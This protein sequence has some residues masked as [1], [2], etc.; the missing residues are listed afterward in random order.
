MGMGG[1]IALLVMVGL[2]V[3]I[4][5][6]L[7]TDATVKVNELPDAT[8]NGDLQDA[9]RLLTWTTVACWVSLVMI[10]IG[11]GIV[12]YNGSSAVAKAGG[13]MINGLL[14]FLLLMLFVMGVMASAAAS[15]IDASGQ[16]VDGDG[17]AAYNNCVAAAIL[18]LTTVGLLIIGMI[19]MA[20]QRHKHNKK[21]REVEEAIEIGDTERLEQLTGKGYKSKGRRDAEKYLQTAEKQNRIEDEK[22][23]RGIPPAKSTASEN[24]TSKS[25][26]SENLQTM[27]ELAKFADQMYKSSKG[28]V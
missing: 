3:F 16:N 10:A 2:L 15:S 5:L 27:L 18:S 4:V 20:A 6:V 21:V 28:K 8:S 17:K 23:K 1:R 14:V 22:A 25:S 26:D 19:M 24:K 12:I 11:I 9:S 7:I 13:G